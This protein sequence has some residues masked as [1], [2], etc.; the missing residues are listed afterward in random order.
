M[1]TLLFALCIGITIAQNPEAFVADVQIYND[2]VRDYTLKLLNLAVFSDI[3]VLLA[4]GVCRELSL[5]ECI[6]I[7]P[8]KVFELITQLG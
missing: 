1:Y 6:M 8:T 7:T 2:K 5:G 4:N 3:Y